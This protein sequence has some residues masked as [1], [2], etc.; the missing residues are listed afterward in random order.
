M[1]PFTPLPLAST[2]LTVVAPSRAGTRPAT[3]VEMALAI[4][5]AW[6]SKARTSHTSWK[7]HTPADGV[8]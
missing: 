1:F 3:A 4:C 7:T 8:L 5:R 6:Y 2:K